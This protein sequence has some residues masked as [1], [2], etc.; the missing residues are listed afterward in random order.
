MQNFLHATVNLA[1]LFKILELSLA[2]LAPFRGIIFYAWLKNIA[3]VYLGH[4]GGFVVAF[5][6]QA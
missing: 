1:W 3:H 2:V 4:L 6:N 5:A